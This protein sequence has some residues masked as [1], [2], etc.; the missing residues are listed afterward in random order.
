MVCPKHKACESSATKYIEVPSLQQQANIR[1]APWPCCLMH[2]YEVQCYLLSAN[3]RSSKH[4]RPF[5][6][7]HLCSTR[8]PWVAPTRRTIRQH[9]LQ[10]LQ[11]YS[12]PIS[13]FIHDPFVAGLP[14]QHFIHGFIRFQIMVDFIVSWDGSIISRRVRDVKGSRVC[15][16]I[17][18]PSQCG[19][20]SPG[21]RASLNL[22]N[23]LASTLLPQRA[24]P[25]ND[26][27]PG[28]SDNNTSCKLRS[29]SK[30]ELT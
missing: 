8:L 1:A 13:P 10:D 2:S 12:T 4:V 21:W 24:N 16:S 25:H 20:S 19:H 18:E 15:Y 28:G 30:F 17:R 11:L 7:G 23:L 6:N 22:H 5:I 3:T 14:N 26:T 29:S 27:N 9:Q